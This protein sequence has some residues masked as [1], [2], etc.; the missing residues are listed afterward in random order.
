[1]SSID[2]PSRASIA[3]AKAVTWTN[4]AELPGPKFDEA[5]VAVGVEVDEG[6]SVM[7]CVNVRDADGRAPVGTDAEIVGGGA[8][9]S[10]ADPAVPQAV[11][12]GTRRA[13]R[14]DRWL[15]FFLEETARGRC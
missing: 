13:E 10:D 6:L 9:E 11:S 14:C 5:G 12:R 2:L 3:G 7:A 15:F 1:M 4:S 8:E